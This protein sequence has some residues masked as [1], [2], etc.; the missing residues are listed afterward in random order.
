MQIELVEFECTIVVPDAWNLYSNSWVTTYYHD[1]R[2]SY[3]DALKQWTLHFGR[4]LNLELWSC[5]WVRS[6]FS[7]KLKLKE[8]FSGY[9][10]RLLLDL[11]AQLRSLLTARPKSPTRVKN[12]FFPTQLKEVF[13]NFGIY[14]GGAAIGHFDWHFIKKFKCFYCS[15]IAFTTTNKVCRVI[16]L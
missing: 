14:W 2:T 6:S 12:G 4:S 5:P 7:T 3:F 1:I 16:F 10:F 15:Q 8:F 9:T 11:R 13:F